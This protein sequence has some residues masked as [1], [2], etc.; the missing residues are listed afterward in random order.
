MQANRENL[1]SWYLSIWGFDL[2]TGNIITIAKISKSFL[3]YV[4]NNL[5]HEMQSWFLGT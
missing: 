1:I 4:M 5:M 3:C 2:G